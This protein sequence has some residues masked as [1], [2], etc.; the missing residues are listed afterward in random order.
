MANSGEKALY[1]LIGGFV[2]AAVALLFAPKSGEETRRYL[3]DR[4]RAG[5][6]EVGRRVQVGREYMSETRR[7]LGDKMTS[8]LEKGRDA[9]NRQKEQIESA[10]EAGRRA[11]HEEKDKLEQGSEG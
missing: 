9:V 3:E 11:Y 7:D 4:Y 1:F 8:T 5:A 2:G 6:E 10:I